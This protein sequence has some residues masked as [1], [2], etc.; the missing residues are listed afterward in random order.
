M[1]ADA[2]EP[3][4]EATIAD[5][6]SH[7]PVAGLAVAVVRGGA[8]ASFCGHGLADIE[9]GEPVGEQTVFRIASI[10]KTITAVAVMQ[11]QEQGLVDLD[12]PVRDYL[13]AFRLIPASPRFR[14]VTL[15]H[16]LT[17]TAGIRAVRTVFD[18][19]RPTLGWGVPAGHAV[20]ALARYYRDGL[21]VDTDPGTKWA[22]SNHGFAVLGQV[23]EDVT[24]TPFD[25]YV[26]EHVFGPAGM[27]R[28]DLVRSERVRSGLATGYHMRSRGLIA[29]TDR[30]NVPVGAGSGYASTSDMARFAAA[31]L[32]GGANEH[33]RILQPQ[34][35]VQMFAP[36]YQPDPRIPGMGLGFF[37]GETG[38]YATVGHDGI[39]PGFHAA[40]LL[41]PEREAGVLAFAN[42]G[43][44][45]PLSVT[46]PVASAVLRR[47]LGVPQDATPAGI[48]QNP[49]IWGQLCGRYSLGRGVLTDPQPRMLGPAIEV[50][51]HR[52]NLVLRGQLPIPAVRRGLRLNP[53]GEDPDVFR[54]ELPGYG[55]GTSTVVFSRDPDGQVTALHLGVQPM[56][57]RKHRCQVR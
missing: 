26:R 30:E 55:S 24:G 1:S 39:W 21:H 43:P 5:I 10:T 16:L 4:L 51:V 32:G 23:V 8:L 52:G 44:F 31:L 40:M 50:T 57:F 46:G 14:P 38:G 56:T 7:W 3:G 41:V 37:R 19:L 11:L 6:L 33:G 17:H 54:V 25:R 18:L 15:R 45:S 53:A 27:S 22:Y 42:T 20:P 48:P 35:L 49:Q 28:S 29:V 2:G 9:S 13:H 36:H 47:L 34:T 12:A